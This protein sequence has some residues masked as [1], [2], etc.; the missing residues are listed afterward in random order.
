MELLGFSP[1]YLR[2]ICF[3]GRK[4]NRTRGV[5]D[6]ALLSAVQAILNRLLETS[7]LR[8]NSRHKYRHV[9]NDSPHLSELFR[10]RTSYDNGA[11]PIFV[12]RRRHT[13]RYVFVKRLSVNEKVL[14]F[15]GTIVGSPAPDDHSLIAPL[16]KRLKG[17][18]ARVRL[19]RYG[20]GLQVFEC[21]PRVLFVGIFNVAA[22]RVENDSDS[23]RI[24]D[25]IHNGLS[26]GRYPLVSV[27]LVKSR[28]R[29]VCAYDILRR[30]H[31]GAIEP[32]DGRARIFL[33][34]RFRYLGYIGIQPDA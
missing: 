19:D 18:S 22:L 13:L 29:L 3:A 11:I 31:D 9:A 16:Q 24:L 8:S 23:R 15:A 12:P 28:V 34:R 5:H 14:K 27:R 4:D 20:I 21:R 32:N 6:E 7:R 33:F 25:D 26:Q 17:F 30:V 10:I 2:K 1:C